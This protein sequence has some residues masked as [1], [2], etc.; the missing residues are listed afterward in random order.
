MERGPTVDISAS[1][2]KRDLFLDAFVKKVELV[3]V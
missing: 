3:T 2:V 1:Y